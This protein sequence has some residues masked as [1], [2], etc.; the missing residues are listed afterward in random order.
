MRCN[1]FIFECV[2]EVIFINF[3]IFC[4]CSI[5]DVFSNCKYIDYT[6]ETFNCC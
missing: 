4:C 6:V 2:G 5:F 1:D 3:P